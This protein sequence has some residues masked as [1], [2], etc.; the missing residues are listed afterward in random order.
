MDLGRGRRISG[1]RGGDEAR[2]LSAAGGR[3]FSW[4]L[5]REGSDGRE[6]AMCC[7]FWELLEW[8][9]L[10]YLLGGGG[11]AWSSALRAR[12]CDGYLKKF[13]FEEPP[14]ATPSP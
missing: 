13:A 6:D 11:G 5:G 4:L 7:A 10:D 9:R 8:H 1:V 3:G 2:W 14:T 12:R